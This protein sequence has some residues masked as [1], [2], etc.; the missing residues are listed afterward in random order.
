MPRSLWTGSLSFGLVNVPVAL[1]SAARD[2]DLHFNQLHAKDGARIE[3]RRFCAEEDREV[4]Y[5]DIGHGYELDS[6]KQVVLTDEELD[7][8]APEKTRMI[9]IDEFVDVC[10]IDPVF[11]DRPYFLIPDDAGEG[12]ARA[13]R[14]LVE[15][16]KDQ[17]RAAVG[18]LVLRTKEHLVALRVREGVLQVTTMIFSDELRDASDLPMPDKR[19]HKPS[20]DEVSNAVALI[21]E[22][23]ADFDPKKLRD[24]HRDRLLK[25]IQRK[26]KGETIKAPASPE[27]P[28][29]VPDLLEALQRSL[30]DVRGREKA[31]AR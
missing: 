31:G 13:Y 15:A 1:Y 11:Y 27:T 14:L 20:K 16:M 12:P 8:A 2:Q 18:R 7:A 24:R 28:K 23:S 9:D 19:K 22:L 17:R 6:G 3:T 21:G 25:V 29:A 10:D 30:E 5:E 4:A 26:R